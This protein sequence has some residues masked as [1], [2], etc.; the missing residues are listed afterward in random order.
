[1]A[2]DQAGH[3]GFGEIV[4]RR[5]ALRL[6]HGEEGSRTKSLGPHIHLIA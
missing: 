1:V 3:R 4:F 2:G 5:N 6:L